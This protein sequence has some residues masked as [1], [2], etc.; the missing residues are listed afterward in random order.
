MRRFLGAF[1]AT[2]GV[3]ALGFSGKSWLKHIQIIA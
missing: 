2:L 3:V 1:E